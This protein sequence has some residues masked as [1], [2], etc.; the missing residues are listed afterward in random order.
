MIAHWMY[1]IKWMREYVFG[2]MKDVCT[3]QAAVSPLS[4]LL[5]FWKLN[6]YNFG[7]TRVIVP[8]D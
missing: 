2:S 6:I 4:N 8:L 7:G 3:I 1:R 5:W